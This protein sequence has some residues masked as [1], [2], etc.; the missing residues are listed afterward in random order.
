MIFA[1]KFKKNVDT[2]FGIYCPMLKG[3]SCFFIKLMKL[4]LTDKT[5]ARR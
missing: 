2:E 4:D 1:V 3:S 5:S